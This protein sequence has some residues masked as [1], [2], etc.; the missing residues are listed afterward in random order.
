MVL[1]TPPDCGAPA[2]AAGEDGLAVAGTVAD[3]AGAVGAAELAAGGVVAGAA[4]VGGLETGALE[5]GGVVEGEP[6]ATRV[7]L[8][9]T[10]IANNR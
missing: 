8:K 6:Q 3:E 9:T 1:K 10:R 4:L 2:D 5:N 7:R